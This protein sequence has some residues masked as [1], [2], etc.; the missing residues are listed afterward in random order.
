MTLLP[1]DALLQQA[2]ALLQRTP[3]VDG[4]VDLPYRLH[5]S[6]RRGRPEDVTQPSGG[7]FDVQRARAGG[8]AAPFMSIYTPSSLESVDDDGQA[9]FSGS[10][11]LADRLIDF[12]DG[13]VD[14]HPDVFASARSPVDVER[15]HR[16]GRIALPLGMEN[17]SPLEGD[18]DHL[19]HFFDRGVRYITLAH[20]RANHVADAATGKVA[21]HDGLSSFGRDVVRGMNDLGMMVDVSHLSDA[22]AHAVFEVTRA[23]VIASH[24]SCRA[25]TPQ[26]IRN[27]PDDVLRGIADSGGVVMITFGSNFVDDDVRVFEQQRQELWMKE[28]RALGD[29]VD[30]DVKE[31][32]RAAFR[33]AHP[34]ARATVGRVVDHI[35]H[36]LDVMGPKHVGLGSDFDGVGDTLPEGLRDVADYPQLVAELL[37]RGHADDVVEGIVGRNL[38]RVW[39]EVEASARGSA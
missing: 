15:A 17:G 28:V 14:E 27:A 21:L 19:Q 13:L 22:A 35:E 11:D 5:L 34:K 26:F 24:S 1:D 20:A 16:D 36:A 38:L 6:A 3:L 9:V 12:V 23:P 18:L 39:S 33:A 31:Q 7:D 25:L 8:L 2:R 29:D 32:A 10:K 30:P 37:R 4:H